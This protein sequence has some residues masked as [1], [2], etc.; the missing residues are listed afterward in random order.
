M[1]PLDVLVIGGGIT[2]AGILRDC[3]LRGLKAALVEKGEPGLGTT[4]NST[5]L[6]HGGLRYLLYDRFET[7]T[8]SW[9][10]GHILRIA[11]PLLKRLPILWPIYSGHAHGIENAE[12]VLEAYEPFQKMKGAKP[13]L[14]LSREEVLRAAPQLK[15]EGLKG[16]LCFDE[17]LVDPVRLVTQN[18][19]SAVRRGATAHYHA[20][21]IEP[22]WSGPGKGRMAGALVRRAGQAEAQAMPARLVVNAAGPWAADVAKRS[23]TDIRLRLQ[24]GTHLVYEG[25]L[26][27]IGLLLEA[28]DRKRYLFVVPMGHKTFVG[29]TDIPTSNGP[30]HLKP[31]EDEIKYLLDSAKRFLPQFNERFTA[32]ACGSRPI[33]DQPGGEKLLSRDYQIFDHEKLERISGCV[34]VAGGKM[35]AFRIMA[36][37]TV[38][39]ICE[40]LGVADKCRTHL[41]TLDG[42]P[43]ANVPDDR[44]PPKN[45]KAFFNRHPR[46][47]E[48]YALSH[49]G[50]QSLK[51]W[52]AK[53][54]RT[55][56]SAAPDL[57]KYYTDP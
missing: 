50:A 8:S 13:H 44:L 19:D 26:T 33:L 21:F 43:V 23:N 37:D 24:Q 38:D 20:E 48:L 35:S 55:P 6:I 4:A 11:R 40:K 41:E 1:E 17:W 2:G 25:N 22:L 39:V 36:E 34:S 57:L 51:H 3:A 49:L 46:L 14:R 10:S 32:L 54:S 15:E 53:L 9:D 18:I 16:G 5:H 47:R 7:H 27:P 12:T 45:L 31:Q 42:K 28:V 29:P 30:D 52:T 56:N